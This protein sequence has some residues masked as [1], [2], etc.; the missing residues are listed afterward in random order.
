MIVLR[1]N[2]VGSVFAAAMNLFD[3]GQVTES[4]NGPTIVAH[5]PITSVYPIPGNYLLGGRTRNANPFFHLMEA[6]WMLGGRNDVHFP[7]RFNK[8]FY[9]Y[10]D[11]GETLHGAYGYRWR[12]FFGFDQLWAIIHELR[13]NPTS[14]R[15]VLAMWNAAYTDSSTPDLSVAANGGKDVP[16]NTHVY[17]DLRDGRLNMQVCCRSNDA[18]WGAY[19]ANVVHFSLLLEYVAAMIGVPVGW[20]EQTSFNLHVYTDVHP[21]LMRRAM[22]EEA[23]AYNP[24]TIF[25]YQKRVPLVSL[26]DI[27]DDE[28]KRF[29]AHA[30][31][32][33]VIP[34]FSNTFLEWVASPMLRA[35][36]FFSAG[37]VPYAY[38]AVESILDDAWRSVCKTWLDETMYRRSIKE[39]SSVQG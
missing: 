23:V 17:F 31:A 11:D 19:G 29:L 22:R 6:L 30:Y 25:R 12:Q 9:E 16:C 36:R 20:Y 18:I 13:K 26:P 2:S 38:A 5:E 4:R 34:E 27:F 3:N 24:H 8:R 37:D 7:A 39:N 35:H 28:V 15:C 10:S 14:R 33:E 1:G 32:G 21:Q